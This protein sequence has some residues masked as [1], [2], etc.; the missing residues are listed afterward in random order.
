VQVKETRWLQATSNSV[1]NRPQWVA[2]SAG[3]HV[4]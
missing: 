2:Q 3:D 4:S 1:Y